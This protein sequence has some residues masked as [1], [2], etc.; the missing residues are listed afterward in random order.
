M[1]VSTLKNLKLIFFGIVFFFIL[2]INT[3]RIISIDIFNLL[4]IVLFAILIFGIFKNFSKIPKVLKNLFI[5][6]VLAS[7]FAISH[8]NSSVDISEDLGFASST[9][10]LPIV[11]PFLFYYYSRKSLSSTKRG[12]LALT[13]FCILSSLPYLFGF[14]PQPE[15]ADDI[16]WKYGLEQ[17]KEVFFGFHGGVATSSKVLSVSLL[18]AFTFYLQKKRNIYLTFLILAGAYALIFTFARTGWFTFLGGLFILY[19]SGRKWSE[20]FKKVVPVLIISILFLGFIVNSNEF[21]NRR[22][23]DN[24]TYNKQKDVSLIEAYG[25]SRLGIQGSAV[26]II[27]DM[28]TSEL[29]FGIGVQE[30]KN[31]MQKYFGSGIVPHNNILMII[32]GGGL[33]MLIVYFFYMIYLFKFIN[34]YSSIRNREYFI[35]LPLVLFGIFIL[36]QIPSHGFEFFTSLLFAFAI[37]YSVKL[38]GQRVLTIL[39]N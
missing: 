29:I 10:T 3:L 23:T 22:L 20:I 19:V 35:K 18:I 2:H 13:S 34:R 11:L 6:G 9:A 4:R 1:R 26:Q 21:I 7:L 12:L 38:R 31:R 36:S 24:K 27:K 25:A 16:L 28:S 15:G 39:K 5:T 37:A 32:I 14:V 8:L 17:G 30:L 33:K